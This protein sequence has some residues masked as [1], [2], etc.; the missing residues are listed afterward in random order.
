MKAVNFMFYPNFEKFHSSSIIIAVGHAFFTLS[1]GMTAILTY[2]ASLDKD[3]NIVKASIWVI[4]MDTSIAILAGLIIFSI[5][6][7]AGQEPSK[8]PGLVFITLPAIFYEMG[9]IGIYLSLLFFIAVL[10]AAITSAVSILEPA[11][12][13]LVERKNIDRKT[14]TYSVSF[15]IYILGIFVLL[16]NTNEFSES[17]TFGNKNLFDWFDFISSAILLP[18]GGMIV[19]IFIGFVLDKEVSRSAI[20]PHIG[21]TYYKIWLFIIRYV[22]PISIILIMLKESGIIKI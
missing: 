15:F 16:S 11:V 21:E 2:A 13:Y 19:S 6:F 3:V 8:G 20:I 4:V 18:I 22:A 1:I 9:T 12:M 14:A 10:F 7:T 17:L 5:T